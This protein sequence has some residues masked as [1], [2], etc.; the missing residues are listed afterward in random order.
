MPC[1][2]CPSD[3]EVDQFLLLPYVDQLLN[4]IFSRKRDCS[5]TSSKW[6][7]LKQSFGQDIIYAV[8]NGKIKTPKTIFFPQW[9]E[10]V[11]LPDGVQQE[12][13]T[14]YVPDNIDRLEETLSG[15][16]NCLVFQI[17]C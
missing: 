4:T 11:I 16:Y 7:R 8:S 3:L 17:V 14:V 5:D 10:G 12:K 2:S 13:F 6:T 9:G 1:P 15:L